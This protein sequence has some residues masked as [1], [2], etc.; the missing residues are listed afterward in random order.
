MEWGVRGREVSMVKREVTWEEGGKGDIKKNYHC[1]EKKE[2][3]A[4]GTGKL[5]SELVK[6]SANS[7]QCLPCPR[8]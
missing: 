7:P 3:K 6:E 2:K 1:R 4:R 8:L 5:N